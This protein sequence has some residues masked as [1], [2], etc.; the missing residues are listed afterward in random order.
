[1]Y[2]VGKEAKYGQELGRLKMQNVGTY[3]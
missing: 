3:L 1:V 2:Q